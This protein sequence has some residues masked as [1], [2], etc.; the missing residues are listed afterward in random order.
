MTEFDK[1]TER[2]PELFFWIDQQFTDDELPPEPSAAE[3]AYMN[4]QA[5]QLLLDFKE[6]DEDL[7]GTI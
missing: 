3:M 1:L 6:H 5:E 4:Q 7:Y 2:H